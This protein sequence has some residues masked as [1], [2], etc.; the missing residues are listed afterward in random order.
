MGY[1]YHNTIANGDFIRDLCLLRE[2]NNVVDDQDLTNTELIY[3]IDLLYTLYNHCYIVLMLV[4]ARFLVF[5]SNKYML[6]YVTF[7]V[8]KTKYANLFIAHTH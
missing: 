2:N 7:C 6:F 4:F 5:Y 1:K 3:M 8:F